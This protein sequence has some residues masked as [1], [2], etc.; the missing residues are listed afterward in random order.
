MRVRRNFEPT[1]C[2]VCHSHKIYY[3][4]VNKMAEYYPE[5]SE[6]YYTKEEYNFDCWEPPDLIVH[7]C[8]E[9]GY[10]WAE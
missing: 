4:Y 2:P 10:I 7:Q 8:I 3:G 9:C 1:M 5:N 6:E